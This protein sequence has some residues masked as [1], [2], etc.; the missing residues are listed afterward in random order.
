MYCNL[1]MALFKYLKGDSI[2]YQIRAGFPFSAFRLEERYLIL[3]TQDVAQKQRDLFKLDAITIAAPA[4]LISA[5]DK[6][7]RKQVAIALAKAV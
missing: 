7:H 2:A 6:G 4:L 1:F 5:I 3:A